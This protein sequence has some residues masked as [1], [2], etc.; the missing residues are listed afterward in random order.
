MRLPSNSAF[1][2][3]I[4]FGNYF[5]GLCAVGLSIEASLQQ[6]YPLN[7][8]LYYTIVFCATILYYTKAYITEVTTDINNK[9]SLWY[10]QFRRFVLFSQII[11]TVIAAICSFIFIRKNWFSITHL[12]L[13][14]WTL[15]LVFP[16][17]AA[18]YYG[19]N[20]KMLK[21]YNLRNTGWLKPFVIGFAWAGAVTVYPVLF[22]SID[23][24]LV[25][26]ATLIG[27]FLFIKNFMFITVLCIMFDIKDYAVDYNHQLKTFV[28]K[29][30]LRKT[31]FYIIIPLCIIGFGTFILFT[32]ARH[33]SFLRIMVNAIPFIALISV[34]YSMYRRKSILYY[35][36]IIDGL[37]LVKALCG[38]IGMLWF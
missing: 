27:S 22:Y 30:G 36:I 17:V 9:R 21:R 15:I 32:T 26:T 19:V 8:L 35:L 25:F 7:S 38:T 20:S 18:L 14:N 1:I 3:F 29:V 13:L 12:S 11:L 37:M 31:I 28:V 24:G 5:Y 16:T 6:L 34:A 33:F 23:Q 2:K 10:V 4:F